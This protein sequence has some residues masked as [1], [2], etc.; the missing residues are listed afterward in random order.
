M[1]EVIE[2]DAK[3]AKEFLDRGEAILVDVRDDFENKMSRVPGSILMPLEKLDMDYFSRQDQKIILYCETGNR[4]MK[5]GR[6]VS[7]SV[8]SPVYSISGG[9]KSW[10][11]QGFPLEGCACRYSLLEQVQIFIG[12]ILF[13][14]ALLTLF[15]SEYYSLISLFIGIGLFNAGVTG[16]C[17]AMKLI[18][19]MPWNKQ[20][21]IC[22]P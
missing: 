10:I 16:R 4:S 22:V 21:R 1:N 7:A 5:A 13:I 19:M 3:T 9:L 18:G 15:I 17:P 12:T 8:E 6:K 20:K 14:G 11:S 2:I